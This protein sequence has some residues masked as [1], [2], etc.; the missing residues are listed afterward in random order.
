MVGL[1]IILLIFEFEVSGSFSSSNIFLYV[2]AEIL[3]GSF[4]TWN[5]MQ[6]VEI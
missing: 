2:S 6:N 3:P 1:D 5:S 4:V